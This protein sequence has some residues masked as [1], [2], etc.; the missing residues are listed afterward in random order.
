MW[1]AQ[2]LPA[3]CAA[4]LEDLLTGDD[5][6]QA[7]T[8]AVTNTDKTTTSTTNPAYTSWVTRDQAVLGYLMYS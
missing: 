7:K 4:R 5:V 3:I 2:V 1:H 6:T 8:I